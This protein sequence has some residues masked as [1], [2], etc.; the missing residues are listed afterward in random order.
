MAIPGW[1]DPA[2]E[3][4]NPHRP[5]ERRRARAELEA[6]LRERQIPLFGAETDEDIVAIV[7]AVEM[8]E[9]RVSQLGGDLFVNTP[10]SSE[11]DDAQFVLPA[12]RDDESAVRYAARVRA[13]AEL[14]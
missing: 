3:E 1:N 8:F 13:A 4:R 11:P 7:N 2:E 12:R 10:E 9:D 5:E 6:R 14:L